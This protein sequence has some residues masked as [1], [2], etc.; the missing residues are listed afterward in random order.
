[1]AILSKEQKPD[2]FESHNSLKFSF[3]NIQ[4]FRLNF[5]GY[6]SFFESNFRDILTLFKTHLGYSIDSSNFFVRGYL[7]LIRKDSVTHVHDLAVYLEEGLPFAQDVYL[8]NP[9]DSYLCF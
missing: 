3:T 7:P 4:G 5:V 1:M 8:E 2:N 9:S 6:E